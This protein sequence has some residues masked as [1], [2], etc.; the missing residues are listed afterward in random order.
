LARRLLVLLFLH[1]I[2]TSVVI[3]QAP[4]LLEGPEAP[5]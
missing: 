1:T 3:I 5:L 4:P 2:I